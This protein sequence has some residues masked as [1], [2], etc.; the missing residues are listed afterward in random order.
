MDA[1]TFRFRLR[2]S[3][4]VL[5]LVATFSA[6]F[7]FYLSQLDLN[8]YRV[9]IEQQLS[10]TLKRPVQIN[11]CKLTFSRGL[12]VALE[13]LQVGN[14]DDI[15]ADIPYVTATLKIWPLL[16]GNFILAEVQAKNPTVKLQIPAEPH[17]EDDNPSYL[18]NG[19][20][21]STLSIDNGDLTISWQD[22]QGDLHEFRVIKI[23]TQLNNWSSGKIGQLT[24]SGKLL[25]YGTDFL[26]DTRLV[27]S[28]NPNIWRNEEFKTKLKI[29]NFP[30]RKI[31]ASNYQGLPELLNMDISCQGIPATGTTLNLTI[32]GTDV[33]QQVLSLS[34]LWTSSKQQDLISNITGELLKLPLSGN[35][36]LSRNTDQTSLVGQLGIENYSLSPQTFAAWRIPNSKQLTG[37]KLDKL[38]ISMNQTWER[39]KGLSTVPNMLFDLAVSNLTWDL[40]EFKQLNDLSVALTLQDNHLAIK[41]GILVGANHSFFFS[42]EI[43]SLFRQ[44]QLELELNFSSE[45]TDL[46]NH[47]KLAK[48]WDITGS[49]PG[50]LNIHG[51]LANPTFTLQADLSSIEAKMGMLLQKKATDR[52]KIFLRGH[53]EPNKFYLDRLAFDLNDFNLTADGNLE[54]NKQQYLF[55][56]TSIELGKL[57][58]YSPL[59]KRIDLTGNVTAE[60]TPQNN[61]LQ[62]TININ[63]GGAH[64]IDLLGDIKSASGEI[65]L[66]RH[67]FTFKK[68]K[69][70]LGD[71]PFIV[72]GRFTN[73]RD[74]LLVLDLNG[75]KARAQ[76]IVFSSRNLNLYDLTGQLQIDA[77]KISFT[78]VNVRLED[79]TIATVKGN[80]SFKNPLVDLDISADKVDVLDII[81]L[82]VDE[83]S[84]QQKTSEHKGAPLNIKV[85]AKQG[86]IGGLSFKNAKGLITGDDQQL[87]VYPLRFENGAG[88]C[89]SKIEFDFNDKI[90][91]LKISGHAEN[92]DA[93]VVYQDVFAKPGLISGLLK[94]DFYIAGN[95]RNEIFWANA[96]GGIHAEIKDGTLRKFHGLAKVFSLLNVS[97]IFSGKLPDMDKDGMPFT[98]LDG[99]V[100]IGDG[101]AKIEDLKITSVA[102]NLSVVGSHHLTSNTLDFMLGIMPLRTV[103]KVISA[104][105]LAGWVLTGKDK[106]LLTAH[107]KIVGDE[108]NPKV[109][110][111]P[112]SSVSNVVFGIFKRTFGLPGKVVDMFKTA[113]PKVT[114]EN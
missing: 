74:P 36:D 34:G 67:G 88:W 80:V 82:F 3:L 24:I 97:Q 60:L 73:W 78:P 77:G 41:K 76:D 20:G 42:G 43:S 98:L 8:V 47:T 13:G 44:P 94:G 70:S 84:N 7:V 62:A 103:D 114:P 26:L 48:D 53:F 66:D 85:S 49:L 111:V 79:D 18:L 19:L 58:A 63:S 95:P 55:K 27:S 52:A 99:S 102:M 100:E 109:T 9:S 25:E 96:K 91:P 11:R 15:V 1:S 61:E 12:A 57:Q 89:E 30:A 59:L 45:I 108:E 32:A 21:I 29:A 104:I 33:R 39:S 75:K 86:K 101:E 87:A 38:M 69:A 81:N 50:A 51:P 37:G 71:S 83:Q 17:I 65:S 6:F 2:I 28:K 5:I 110:A 92:I 23:N 40:P 90:M 4:Y 22:K 72:D 31:L 10:S 93:S 54:L 64:I 14:D 46:A 106:A 107:F 56:T 35:M 112:I 16:R 113:P 68:F 105:P